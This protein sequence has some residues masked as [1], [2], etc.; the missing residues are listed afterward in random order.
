MSA[1]TGSR[2]RWKGG[3]ISE[4]CP[5]CGRHDP[6]CAGQPCYYA[7]AKPDGAVM[8]PERLDPKEIARRTL[9]WLASDEG[10]QAMREAEQRVSD[11]EKSLKESQNITW[12]MMHAP[13]TI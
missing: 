10:K 6:E 5:K 13:F 12:E 8:T 4:K 9:E 3:V 2:S 11:F 7:V 1:E